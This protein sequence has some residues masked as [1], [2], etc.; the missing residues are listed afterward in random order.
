MATKRKRA[1]PGNIGT[2]DNQG[3]SE[4]CVRFAIGKAIANHLYLQ[5][6]IDIDQS[7]IMICLVQAIGSIAPVNPKRYNNTKIYVQDKE[8]QRPKPSKCARCNETEVGIPD[9][10]WWE[11]IKWIQ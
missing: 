10:S 4:L 9:K 6:K 7:H 1:P 11:V 3:G 5:E 8:N 2:V